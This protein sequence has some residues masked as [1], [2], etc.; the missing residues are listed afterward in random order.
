LYIFVKTYAMAYQ[1]VLTPAELILVEEKKRKEKDAKLLR[2]YQCLSLLH[3]QY[4]KKEVA[5]I[6]NVNIDTVTD[7]VK[8]YI[9]EGLPSIGLLKYDG[10]RP[11]ALDSIKEDITAYVKKENINNLA[12]L[13]KII[14]KKHHLTIEHSWLSR[15]CKK[16]SISLIKRQD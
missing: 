10:R 2:R 8:L 3:D 5:R 16:N 7:W 4:P 6:L 13:Q 9:K 14:Q 11:S 1:V 15:Y 12:E